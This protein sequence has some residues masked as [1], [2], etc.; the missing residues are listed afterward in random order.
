VQSKDFGV[1]PGSHFARRY[2]E[3]RKQVA[4]DLIQPPRLDIRI[5]NSQTW[6][7]TDCLTGDVVG[8]ITYR[9]NSN[10][11]HYRPWLLMNGEHCEFGA[12]VA[13]LSQAA[14]AIEGEVMKRATTSSTLN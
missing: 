5:E 2:S 10:G 9:H 1:K 12:P 13:Q 6:V 14:E 8:G 11:D 7:L 4:K 3:D